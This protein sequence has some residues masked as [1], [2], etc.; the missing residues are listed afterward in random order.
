MNRPAGLVELMK[1]GKQKQHLRHLSGREPPEPLAVPEPNTFGGNCARNFVSLCTGQQGFPT[2]D[3]ADGERPVASKQPGPQPEVS[4]W[5]GGVILLGKASH[6][7][8]TTPKR[9]G[10]CYPKISAVSSF[11]LGHRPVWTCVAAISQRAVFM[12]RSLHLFSFVHAHP[13]GGWCA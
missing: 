12:A 11:N 8:S 7:P 6:G 13:K 2:M 3:R 9:V 1:Q 5:Y 4:V 10:N